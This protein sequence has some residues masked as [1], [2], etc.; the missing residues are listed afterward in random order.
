MW[1]EVRNNTES[2]KDNMKVLIVDFD[3][4]EMLYSLCMCASRYASHIYVC[5]VPAYIERLKTVLS[6]SE[7]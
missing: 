6:D 3:H 5:S 7:V 1:Q 4:Y 2:L